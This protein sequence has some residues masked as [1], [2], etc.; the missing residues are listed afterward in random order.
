VFVRT[1]RLVTPASNLA[2][3][4]RFYQKMNYFMMLRQGEDAGEIF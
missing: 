4:L 3:H 1:V 2:P